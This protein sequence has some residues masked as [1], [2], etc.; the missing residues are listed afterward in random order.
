MNRKEILRKRNLLKDEIE[1]LI[2]SRSGKS[3]YDDTDLNKKIEA[4]KKEYKFFSNMLKR[5]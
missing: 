3:G 1:I 4:K 2:K 5:M